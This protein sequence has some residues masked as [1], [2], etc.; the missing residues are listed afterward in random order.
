MDNNLRRNRKLFLN[1]ALDELKNPRYE[2]R[3]EWLDH[4]DRDHRTIVRPIFV[5]FCSWSAFA[6]YTSDH[7]GFLGR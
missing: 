2:R 5:V 3:A 4:M 1:K 6:A 7:R